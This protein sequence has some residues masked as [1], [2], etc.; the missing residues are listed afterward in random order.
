MRM[1]LNVSAA[2]LSCVGLGLLWI[3]AGCG[4]PAP[5]APT[6]PSY[7]ELVSI[8]GDE[9]AA[10]D[11]LESKRADLVE[12]HEEQLQ[13]SVE[14]ATA[15]LGAL[16]GAATETGSQLNLDNTG[17]PNDLLDRAI[18]HAEATQGIAEKALAA[19]SSAAEPSEEEAAKH[20]ELTEKFEAEL[21]ALD[22]EIAEQ[23]A[24]VDRARQARDAAEAAQ[25]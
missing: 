18:A 21:A 20:A 11:R 5:V 16:L 10:L 1:K 22:V 2:A 3:A 14:D 25:Q 13:P 24:R 12:K 23:K 8:Y 7:A 19:A 15:A 9:M 17:D 6:G 4:S